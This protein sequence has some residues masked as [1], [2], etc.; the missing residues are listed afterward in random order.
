MS[1]SG[2]AQWLACW[3]HNPKVPGSKPGSAM[4]IAVLIY[5][6]D[7]AGMLYVGQ[8][9][10]WPSGLQPRLSTHR[11]LVRVQVST[12]LSK[13]LLA[14][15][16][17]ANVHLCQPAESTM[18]ISLLICVWDFLGCYMLATLHCG[19]VACS[20]GLSPTGARFEYR[21]LPFCQ[22]AVCLV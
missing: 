12:I 20:P 22:N 19:R 9:A 1:T 16:R 17:E 3:A 14:W 18:S 6:W 5:I 13:V 15:P 11:C 7:F 10:L 21:R 4:P 8:A 2:M